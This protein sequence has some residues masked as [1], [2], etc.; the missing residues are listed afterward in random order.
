MQNIPLGEGGRGGREG[1]INCPY[2]WPFRVFRDQFTIFF[3]KKKSGEGVGV[4]LFVDQQ[5]R[6]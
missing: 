5:E 4:L 6:P 3:L 1:D 2:E